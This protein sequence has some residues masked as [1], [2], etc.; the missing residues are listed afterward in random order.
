MAIHGWTVES[1]SRLPQFNSVDFT[2]EVMV[3][4]VVF[5]TDTDFSVVVVEV[6]IVV[7]GEVVT[8]VFEVAAL[9]AKKLYF[10]FFF[11][12]DLVVEVVAASVVVISLSVELITVG[13]A[14]VYIRRLKNFLVVVGCV[15]DSISDPLRREDNV[16]QG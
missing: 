12:G 6:P 1:S 15:D 16:N 8:I 5:G 3:I 9:L 4:S 2:V 11:S 14:S 10:R 7:L 13:G